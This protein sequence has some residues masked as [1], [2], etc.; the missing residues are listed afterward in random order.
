MDKEAA[1]RA[2]LQKL[3][4][5]HPELR[6]HLIPLLRETEAKTAAPAPKVLKALGQMTRM[7]DGTVTLQV[8][9]RGGTVVDFKKFLMA[10]TRRLFQVTF[11]E[12]TVTFTAPPPGAKGPEEEPAA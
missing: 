6:E 7:P 2:D 5:D 10:V 3:A 9:V 8:A 4:T 12:H 11:D 1:L